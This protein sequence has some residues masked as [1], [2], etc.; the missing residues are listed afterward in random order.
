MKKDIKLE[1]R[2]KSVGPDRITR[3]QC[4][5]CAVELKEIRATVNISDVLATA[6]LESRNECRRINEI[7]TPRSLS[8]A[9]AHVSRLLARSL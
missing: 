4:G 9:A 5:I 2:L 3:R 8:P 6:A 1:P 7:N